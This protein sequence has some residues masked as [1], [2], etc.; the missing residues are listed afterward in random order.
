[1]DATNSKI[2]PFDWIIL[3]LSIYVVVEL[4]LSLVLAYAPWVRTTTEWVD[5][6]IC[7]VFIGDF[8][9]RLRGA[10]D[11][12]A[13]IAGNWIDLAS[14]IPT[15]GML[16]AGRVARII[17]IFRLFR[18]GRVFVSLLQRHQSVNTFQLV[19]L[20]NVLLVTLSAIALYQLEQDAN[21]FFETIADAVWWSVITTTTLGFVQDVAPVTAEGKVLSVFLIMG[22]LLLFGTFT[23]MVAD[24]F[25]SD[26][27]ILE[28]LKHM[29][30]RM[31][32]IEE[33]LDQLN[34]RGAPR[35][36]EDA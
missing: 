8:F 7:M 13:F 10:E 35:G 5:F 27:D 20:L 31:V 3:G 12:R 30:E 18:S 14:S 33:K 21:P 6:G 26:E 16:R 34:A 11:R 15:V 2:R 17:R 29:D 1:M 22:G 32:R 25:I 9:I 23:A 19:V 28:R 24:H 36:E 4:Y